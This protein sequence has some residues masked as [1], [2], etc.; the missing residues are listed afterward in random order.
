MTSTHAASRTII[1]TPRAIFRA[2]IDPDS[3]ACW[4]APTGMTLRIMVF[5][6]RP[7][8]RYRLALCY[9]DPSAAPGKSTADSDIV[10]GQFVELIAEERI[11]EDV[12]FESDH[13]AF[14]GTMR[15]TTSLAPVA[16]GTKVTIV[17][18]NVPPGISEED[19]RVGMQSTLKNLANF[20]E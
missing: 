10:D 19:H 12:T 17:T 20:L 14:A 16:G 6:P 1:A 5:E 9:D 13:P 4:R 7:G 3:M 11:I 15:I 18:E 8:G 2:L